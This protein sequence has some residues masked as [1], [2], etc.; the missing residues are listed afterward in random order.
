MAKIL[1][2]LLISMIQPGA[3]CLHGFEQRCH[4]LQPERIIPGT[5]LNI[6]QFVSSNTTLMLEDND[7][8]CNR[9]A[10]VTSANICRVAL[11]I[12]TSM[13]S[14]IVFEAWLPKHWN[15][16]FLATGNGGIDGCIKYEDLAYT[17]SQ[18]FAAVGANNGHNGT[19]GL[20]FYNHPDTVIDFAWRSLHTSADVGKQLT[21]A[22]YG[23]PH[24]KSYYLGCSL[25][26]RQG[27]GNAEKFPSDFDG[28]VAGAPGVDFNNL[29]SW[30][31]HFFPLTGAIGSRDSVTSN[32][33]KTWIHDEVLKQCDM[34]DGV[35]DG[36]IENPGLC[37]FDPSRLLCAGNSTN[38]CLTQPQVLRLRQIYSDYKYPNGHTIFPAMQP[39]SEVNAADGLYAGTA[40]K[41]SEDWFKYVVYNDPSWNAS[42]FNF[43]DAA[44]AERLNPGDIRTF[45]SLLS[46][47]ERRGGKLLI[48]HGRQDNQITSFNSDRFYKHLKGQR[49]YTDMDKWVRYFQISGMN[50]CSTGPG[51][52]VLGQGGNAA[53]AG[54]PFQAENNVLKAMVDWV[55]QSVAPEHMQGT[56]FV[57]DSVALGVDFK[58]RHCRYPL[59][60]AYIGGDHK[61]A[62]SWECGHGITTGKP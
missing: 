34:I 4:D 35:E 36:I 58:R 19:G 1:L 48:F 23:T 40:W 42:R 8:T 55:E 33:W 54:I 44:V 9:K 29:Y 51:A 25:G 38:N 61:N 32:A 21:K 12:K 59:Y 17:S 52:W 15:G 14:S 22:L 53:A 57:N 5:T 26:G 46:R 37:D 31:A 10:Q 39:G 16:R 50:H 47:F 24:S 7:I 18:G 60:N 56:K 11:T 27:I 13:Q 62:S 28:I 43:E 3:T 20:P 41:P 30:R 2:Y 45:P 49:S 6:L